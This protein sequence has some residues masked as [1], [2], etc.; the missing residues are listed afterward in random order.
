MTTARTEAEALVWRIR[1]NGLTL[2]FALI[3]CE[4][5]AVSFNDDEDDE[6]QV[7]TFSDDSSITVDFEDETFT[8]DLEGF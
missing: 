1:E 2:E 3:E 4:G 8:H 6:E 7:F 5:L